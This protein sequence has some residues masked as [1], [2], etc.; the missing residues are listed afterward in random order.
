MK[1]AGVPPGVATYRGI[2]MKVAI[3]TGMAESIS[4]G[5]M[6]SSVSLVEGGAFRA[7]DGGSFLGIA[8]YAWRQG[9]RLWRKPT[10]AIP[11]PPGDAG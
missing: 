1:D 2:C 5:L 3:G 6:G 11:R 9:L 10:A 7:A 4:F 8:Y